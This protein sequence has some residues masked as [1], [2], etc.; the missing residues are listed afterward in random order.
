MSCDEGLVIS[1]RNCRGADNFTVPLLSLG[2]A[3]LPSNTCCS[4][5]PSS[6][7]SP[8]VKA[9]IFSRAP[10]CASGLASV[11]AR[12]RHSRERGDIGCFRET[13]TANFPA[14]FM[15][16]TLSARWRRRQHTAIAV[17]FLRRDDPGRLHG[18]DQARGAVITDLEPALDAGD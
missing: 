9:T 1:Q 16:E 11:A 4:K 13:G 14:M 6:P 7:F 15:N 3:S 12:A 17:V 5:R 2:T 10:A 18:L 8:F